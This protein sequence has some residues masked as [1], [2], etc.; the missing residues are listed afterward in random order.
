MDERPQ[1]H[2]HSVTQVNETRADIALYCA[3]RTAE[4]PDESYE[5]SSHIWR[6]KSHKL[7]VDELR[8]RITC[9]YSSRE[10]I[11]VIIDQVCIG[12]FDQTTR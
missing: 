5:T 4:L 3:L 2:L 1:Q 12:P 10:E 9:A 11:G 8:K 6:C 7:R